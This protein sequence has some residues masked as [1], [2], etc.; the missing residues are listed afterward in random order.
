MERTGKSMA[1]SL[2]LGPSLSRWNYK[3]LLPSTFRRYLSNLEK[4]YKR[5]VAT[6]SLITESLSD[7]SLTFFPPMTVL[8]SSDSICVLPQ[9]D[10]CRW[11]ESSVCHQQPSEKLQG[12]FAWD[13]GPRQ[14]L[15]VCQTPE[16]TCLSDLSRRIPKPLSK[17]HTCAPSL[18]S[19]GLPSRTEPVLRALC[20][21]SVPSLQPWSE[22]GPGQ[23]LQSLCAK[24]Q[25]ISTGICAGVQVCGLRC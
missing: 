7:C 14:T 4:S 23:T 22:T 18:C 12:S 19:W 24:G 8:K 21:M 10:S 5:S 11:P 15:S 17:T 1:K 20:Q 2:A 9:P 16:G 25:I 6:P 13:S 3:A